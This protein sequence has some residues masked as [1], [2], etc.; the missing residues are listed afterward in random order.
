MTA[1]RSLSA[2]S[3]RCWGV[4]GLAAAYGLV[5]DR[6]HLVPR[7]GAASESLQHLTSWLAAAHRRRIQSRLPSGTVHARAL[8]HKAA[9][10][11]IAT[12]GKWRLASHSSGIWP[13][14]ERQIPAGS[15]F[16]LDDG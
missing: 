2:L 9:S 10:A 5:R 15:M 8:I 13:L 11:F 14:F 16:I 1:L 4:L 12:P 6:A 3:S 7:P